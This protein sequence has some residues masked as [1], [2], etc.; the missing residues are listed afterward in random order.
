LFLNTFSSP[1]INF[2]PVFLFLPLF[3]LLCFIATVSFLSEYEFV[4]SSQFNT[5]ETHSSWHEFVKIVVWRPTAI[6]ASCWAS[7]CYCESRR[8]MQ[9]G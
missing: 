1:L 3:F 2:F 5:F 6:S 8:F 7:Y 9:R 4:L